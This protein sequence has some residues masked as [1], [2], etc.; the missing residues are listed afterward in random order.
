MVLQGIAERSAHAIR[1][2]KLQCRARMGKVLGVHSNLKKA[3]P[4]KAPPC[5]SACPTSTGAPSSAVSVMPL[6]PGQQVL[7]H[8][9]RVR[10]VRA[11]RKAGGGWALP[12]Q[13][14]HDLQQSG[15]HPALQRCHLGFKP[16]VHA[17]SPHPHDQP[18]RQPARGPTK[19]PTP[20]LTVAHALQQLQVHGGVLRRHLLEEAPHRAVVRGEGV[21][22]APDHQHGHAAGSQGRVRRCTSEVACVHCSPCKGDG[23]GEH[24]RNPR[25]STIDGNVL[26]VLADSAFTPPSPCPPPLACLICGSS[27]SGRGP[28]GPVMMDTNASS[29]PSSPAAQQPAQQRHRALRPGGSS[30]RI[31]SERASNSPAPGV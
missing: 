6:Q 28:G 7:V 18:A 5:Q 23:W 10:V 26:L 27:S 13:S 20:S 14:K 31:A 8:Q 11:C 24:T 22:C 15:P 1:R 25:C 12:Q 21:G 16:A 29:A 4:E 30:R 19:H 2:H 17:F 3:L 9:L